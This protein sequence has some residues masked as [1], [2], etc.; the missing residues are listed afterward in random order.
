ME[1]TTTSIQLVLFISD[2]SDIN[3]EKLSINIKD[4]LNT[5]YK[6]SGAA[7]FFPEVPGL[8]PEVPRMILQSICEEFKFQ[9]SKQR[10]DIIIST[11]DSRDSK[12]ALRALF[13]IV[14]HFKIRT[15]RIGYNKHYE[16]ACQNADS[17]IRNLLSEKIKSAEEIFIRFN[18]KGKHEALNLST[19]NVISVFT[20]KNQDT[21]KLRIS[22]DYNSAAEQEYIFFER[23]FISFVE[24]GEIE[25]DYKKIINI[26]GNK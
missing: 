11:P 19:N 22:F 1:L 17:L 6:F 20:E 13:E 25:A 18:S 12:Q 15:K 3:Y 21:T 26:I 16:A 5:W 8:P 2:P 4:T 7:M 24:K 14:S 23:D 10:I 9:L